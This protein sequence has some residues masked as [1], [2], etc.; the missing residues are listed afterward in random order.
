M[1]CPLCGKPLVKTKFGYGCNGY[2]ESG[3]R[4]VI[5]QIAGKRL[6]D[7]QIK[8]LLAGKKVTVNGM[9]KKNEEKFNAKVKM[10]TSG[11]DKGKLV[12]VK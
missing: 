1:I 4:F 11:S 3:C 2:R 9:K 10:I 12:F 8:D 7:G 5:G 6:G